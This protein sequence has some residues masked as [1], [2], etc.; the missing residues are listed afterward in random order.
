[1][2]TDCVFCKLSKTDEVFFKDNTCYAILDIKEL[3]KGHALLIPIKH[4]ESMLETPDEVITHMY[5]VA[6]RLSIKMK[7][8]LGAKGVNITTSCGP[9]AHQ[10]VMHFHIHIIPRYQRK[11]NA[12][13]FFYLDP[14][15]KNANERKRRLAALKKALM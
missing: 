9:V 2:A 7:K 8:I 3:T 10:D 5:L 13:R 15:L 12:I 6:K 1:M 4:Y 14:K 11:L